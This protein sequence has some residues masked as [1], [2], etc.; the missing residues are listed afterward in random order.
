M[1]TSSV[2]ALMILRVIG[3]MKGLAEL[4]QSAERSKAEEKINM[5]LSHCFSIALLYQRVFMEL[6]LTYPKSRNKQKTVK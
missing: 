1:G 3:R 4:L 2:Q 6:L 5:L